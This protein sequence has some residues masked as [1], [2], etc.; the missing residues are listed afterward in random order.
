MIFRFNFEETFAEELFSFSKINQYLDRKEYREKWDEW[1]IDN[2]EKIEAETRRLES[3]GYKGDV[4]EKM[5]KSARYYFRT[6]TSTEPKKRKPYLPQD[7]AILQ[8]IDDFIYEDRKNADFTPKSSFLKWSANDPAKSE[9]KKTF[10][11][12]YYLAKNV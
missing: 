3:L 8:E 2:S 12:R 10:K 11:N 6:K 4:E 9:F 5:F 7:K 1:V